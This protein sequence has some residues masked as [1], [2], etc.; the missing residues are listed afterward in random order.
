MAQLGGGYVNRLPNAANLALA[1][2]PNAGASCGNISYDRANTYAALGPTYGALD[3]GTN[4]CRLLI[5]RPVLQEGQRSFRIIDAFSRIVRLGEGLSSSGALSEAAMD[6]ALSAL[7]VCR[8]KL[9]ARNV[10]RFRLV[11]TEACRAASNGPAFIETVR[12]EIGLDLEIVDRRTEAHLAAAGCCELADE[13]AQ[14]IVLFDIGGGSSE[15]VWLSRS[16]HRRSE[17]MGASNSCVN[18]WTS[19]PLGVVSLCEKFGGVHVTPD[20]FEEMIGH[21]GRHL[22][23]FAK[24]A[25]A[26]QRCGNFHLLG[27]SGTVTTL[28][29]LHLGLQRYDRRQVDGLWM[30]QNEIDEVTRRLLNM[31]YEE[32]IAH[33]CIGSERADLVLAGCAIFEAIRRAF[34]AQRV[35][36]ADRGLRE[37]LLMQMMSADRVWSAA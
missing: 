36:V 10:H 29:G 20:V 3:L 37:G 11:A 19:L 7:E 16:R 34:P 33:G 12:R 8:D 27:T 18:L 17:P 4:N 28:A 9:L 35:R 5:A 32:R 14:A 21:V 31:S 1:A 26:E 30:Q 15:L 13:D 6:R 22:R 23:P 25:G 2:S 24:R